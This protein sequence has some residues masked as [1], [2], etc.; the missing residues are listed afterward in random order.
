MLGA[1][2]DTISGNFSPEGSFYGADVTDLE[3][4][5]PFFHPLLKVHI[6]FFM[7]IL[8]SIPVQILSSLR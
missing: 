5:L 6:L 8:I 7:L 3:M 4:A 1:A 2:D